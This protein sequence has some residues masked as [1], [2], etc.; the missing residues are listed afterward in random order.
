MDTPD[1][2]GP[3]GVPRRERLAVA[4]QRKATYRGLMG[5]LK[6]RDTIEVVFDIAMPSD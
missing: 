4:A 2:Y 3:V 5:P 6:V 1:A